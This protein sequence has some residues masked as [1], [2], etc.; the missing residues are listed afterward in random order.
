M[1][2]RRARLQGYRQPTESNAPPHIPPQCAHLD[3]PT[4]HG[5]ILRTYARM[6]TPAGT[7]PESDIRWQ[8]DL[9]GG[10]LM[11]M[12][13]VLSATRFVL[14]AGAPASV[15]SAKA[16]PF[17]KDARVDEAMEATLTFTRGS[18]EGADGDYEVTSQIYTVRVHRP[19]PKR[20]ILTCLSCCS[21]YETQF[22]RFHHTARMGA[23]LDRS[24]DRKR[25]DLLLQLY[26]GKPSP[27]STVLPECSVLSSLLAAPVPLH[28]RD[29]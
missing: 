12:T 18:A 24:R 19:R 15:L 28:R 5:K 29:R 2:P 17:R 3:L 14:D 25:H 11:D 9:G 20:M 21:G 13:Y 4:Q 10:S 1:P 6:T 7:V 8:F 23:A 27:F 16:R 22:A 26:D